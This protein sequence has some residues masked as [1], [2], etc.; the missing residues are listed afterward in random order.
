MARHRVVPSPRVYYVDPNSFADVRDLVRQ[1]LM[2]DWTRRIA[3]DISRQ[4]SSSRRAS[5]AL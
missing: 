4:D 3:Q 1:A 5:G 2:S